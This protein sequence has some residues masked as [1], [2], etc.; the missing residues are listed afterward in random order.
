MTPLALKASVCAPVPVMARFVKVAT[1]FA[2]LTV[3]VPLSVPLPD[4]LATVTASV[5]LVTVF[6]AASRTATTGCCVN[7]APLIAPPGCVVMTSCVGVPATSATDC[8][9]LV[10]PDDATV[11]V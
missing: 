11:S 7:A 4:P 2:A 1:P 9:A 5:L 8:V 10:S 3:V 6:P